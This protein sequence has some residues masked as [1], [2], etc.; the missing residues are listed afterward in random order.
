[1]VG[2]AIYKFDIGNPNFTQ[3]F[4]EIRE[5][6]LGWRGLVV[7]AQNLSCLKPRCLIIEGF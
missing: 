3:I 2:S 1:L 5:K 4:D 6:S 7:F